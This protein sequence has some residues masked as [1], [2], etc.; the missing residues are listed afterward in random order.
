MLQHWSTLNYFS[1]ER[2]V[3]QISCITCNDTCN[4]ATRLNAPVK[5]INYAC[6][7]QHGL[8]KTVITAGY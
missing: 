5:K 4:Q 6:F 3:N 7:Q 8:L 1:G 2:T